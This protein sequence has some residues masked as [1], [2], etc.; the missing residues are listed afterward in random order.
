MPLDYLMLIKIPVSPRGE[1]LHVQATSK[2]VQVTGYTPLL[3]AGLICDKTVHFK[4]SL[5]LYYYRGLE[6]FLSLSMDRCIYR[7]VEELAMFKYPLLPLK[8]R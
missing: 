5:L 3:W 4:L 8:L 2:A 1:S 6:F 7:L